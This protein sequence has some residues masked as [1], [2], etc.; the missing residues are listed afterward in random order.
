MRVGRR[1]TRPLH[2]RAQARNYIIP[3]ANKSDGGTAFIWPTVNANLVAA[4]AVDR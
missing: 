1:Y 3:S 4:I 2:M